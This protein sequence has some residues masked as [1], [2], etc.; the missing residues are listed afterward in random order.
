MTTIRLVCVLAGLLTCVCVTAAPSICVLPVDDPEASTPW[1]PGLAAA[2]TDALSSTTAYCV[3]PDQ[4]VLDA[5]GG[6]HGSPPAAA[7]AA[8]TFGADAVIGGRLSR[9]DGLRLEFETFG[10][11]GAIGDR[12]GRKNMLLLGMGLSVPASLVAGLAP[13]EGILFLARV[14]GGVSAGLAYPTTLALITAPSK[15]N[16]E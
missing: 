10:D 14:I 15:A 9:A 7:G 3:L 2:M 12:Y 16:S 5:L 4:Q 1:G 8:A 13:N 6:S 11:V